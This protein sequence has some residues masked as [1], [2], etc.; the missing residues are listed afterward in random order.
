MFF[1]VRHNLL[2]PNR[3]ANMSDGWETRRRRGPGHDWNLVALAGRARIRAIELDTNHFKG[4]FPDTCSIEACDGN[5]EK[6]EWR[7]LLP[8]TKLQAHTRHFFVE[9]LNV[10]GPATHVRLNVFPDGGVSRMRVLG[11]LTD[12]ARI[13]LGLERLASLPRSACER[14]LLGCCGS[15]N[16]ASEVAGERPFE[17]E[18]Q[19]REIADRVWAGL[20][21]E[22]WLEAF[23]AHP[24]IGGTTK[25]RW[26]Q[27]EQKGTHGASTETMR[28]LASE[29]ERYRTKFGHVYLVCATGKTADEML[30]LL[31]SRIDHDPQKEIEV[32]AEEQRKITHLRLRKL[33]LG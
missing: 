3:A 14:E 15:K 1:G 12:D 26:S 13:A 17:T 24:A 9:E 30:A 19:L 29:N 31:R 28:A 32:A 4:N 5:P 23:A 33:L 10:D 20:S 6:S 2:M 18:E 27:D 21:R 16:W 8:R 25:S 22:D 7:E 11:T